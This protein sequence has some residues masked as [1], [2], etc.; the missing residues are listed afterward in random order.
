MYVCVICMY[1]S[2]STLPLPRFLRI[3]HSL[4]FSYIFHILV[5]PLFPFLPPSLLP[6]LWC[7]LPSFP[8]P[9][10]LPPSLP[11]LTWLQEGSWQ[12]LTVEVAVICVSGCWKDSPRATFTSFSIEF[13]CRWVWYV[14]SSLSLIRH[15]YELGETN[16]RG[17]NRAPDEADYQ[18]GWRTVIYRA[19]LVYLF[20]ALILRSLLPF[21]GNLST[22]NAGVW[23][24]WSTRLIIQ[25]EEQYYF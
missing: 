18:S 21:F 12:L 19:S 2:F 8:L 23:V 13:S 6:S 15:L 14:A 7:V 17:A 22:R 1:T 5:S 4:L 16:C 9:A 10:S 11:H 25:P 3:Q 20:G 24:V